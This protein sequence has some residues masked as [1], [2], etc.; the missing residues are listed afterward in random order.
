[1]DPVAA[2]SS[3]F[4]LAQFVVTKVVLAIYAE[5]YFSVVSLRYFAGRQK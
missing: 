2:V 4:L 3:G 5:L 1:M